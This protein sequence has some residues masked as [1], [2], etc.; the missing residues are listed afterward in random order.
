MSSKKICIV[1][2]TRTGSVFLNQKIA[3][4]EKI[5]S[6]GEVLNHRSDVFDSRLKNNFGIDVTNLSEH[7]KNKMFFQ[8]WKNVGSSV[9]RIMPYQAKNKSIIHEYLKNATEIIYH[10]RRDTTA[11]V[12]STILAHKSGSY[13]ANR[14]VV[15]EEITAIEFYNT[16][17]TIERRYKEIFKLYKTYPGRISCLEDY[18]YLP[19]KNN[20]KYDKIYKYNLI[21]IDESFNKLQRQT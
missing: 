3:R 21:N 18:E 11:Q 16:A 10:Y 20:Y 6:F 14:E 2:L 9:C 15:T 12:Y 4:E 13:S 19:Y 5:F 17:K 7:N 1:T 8:Q